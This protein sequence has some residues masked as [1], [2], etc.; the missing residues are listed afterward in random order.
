LQ[1]GQSFSGTLSLTAEDGGTAAN[2]VRVSSYGS[3]R[4]TIA[5]GANSGI[6]VYNVS[7]IA[8]SNLI[9]SGTLAGNSA[10]GVVMY[11]DL[12]GAT[13][14]DYLRLFNLDI[15][16]FGQSGVTLGAWPSDGSKSGFRDVQITHVKAFGNADAGIQTYGYFSSSAIGWSHENVYIGHCTTNDN[17]GIAFK[18]S[19]SGSGIVLADVNAATIERCVSF[20][21]GE[22]NNWWAGGP[23]GIWTWDAN[24]VVIQFNESY[25]NKTGT[26]D[27]GGFDLDGGVTNSIMQYN[28]SHDNAGAGYLLAQFGTA[29]AFGNNIVRYNISQNDSRKG[30]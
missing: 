2:P 3:G 12:P 10:S 24:N 17:K 29:R 27:G 11:T 18:G 26:I 8:I 28:Y 22:N 6:S 30:I 5:A 1:G 16:G 20:N 13:K 21:N 15:S 4:A 14:L 23:V 7:G 9:I 25:G 19:N